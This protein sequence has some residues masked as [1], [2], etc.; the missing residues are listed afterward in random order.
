MVRLKDSK[1]FKLLDAE[2][3][4]QFQHGAI[5]GKLKVVCRICHIC[6]SIPTWCD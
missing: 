5:K 3:N 6:L 4:F 1:G 2:E